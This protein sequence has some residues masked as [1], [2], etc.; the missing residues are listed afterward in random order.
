MKLKGRF[1]FATGDGSLAMENAGSNQPQLVFTATADLYADSPVFS[2][3]GKQI[4]FS[5]SS[6]TKDGAVL[7]DIRVMNTDGTNERVVAAPKDP[8]I[9]YGFPAWSPD[10]KDLYFTQSSTVPPSSQHDEIDAVSVSGGAS[11]KLL[12]NAREATVSPDG[13]KIAYS[14]LNFQTYSVGLWIANIDGSGRRQLL[15]GGVFSAVYGPRFSP[16]MQNIVFA[17]SGPPNKKLPGAY[18]FDPPTQDTACAEEFIFFCFAEKAE[19]HGL[20]WDLWLVNLEGTKFERLTSMG[21]DSPVPAWSA[22]GKQIAIYD[23][24]GIYI[25]DVETKKIYQ[26]SDS[27]GYGGFDWR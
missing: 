3:D 27:A 23:A 11:R 24:T 12:D 8:K 18:A 1:V 4:A 7:Q 10:G 5:A 9:T 6:F 15:P 20:P 14:I 25:I 22:D 17:E 21:A 13:K 26:V 19:A 16:N 2:P